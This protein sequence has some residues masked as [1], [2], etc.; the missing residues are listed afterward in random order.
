MAKV[1]LTSTFVKSATC[2]ED[3]SRIE[4]FDTATKGFSLEV[5]TSGGRTYYRR[6][7]DS[8]GRLR[9]VKLG[10]ARELSLSDARTLALR[11]G[12]DVALGEDP[13]ERKRKAKSVPTFAEFIEQQYTP[14]IKTYKRSWADDVGLLRNHLLP[15]LGKLHLDEITRQD[16]QKLHH[17]RRAAGAAP[18][19]CN[20]L[21]ILARYAFNLALRWE[22]PG[23]KANPCKGVPL[24]PEENQR[25]RYLTT[26]EAQRLYRAVCESDNPMLKYIIPALLLSGARKQEVLTARWEDFDFERRL[27]RIPVTK[28]GRPRHV[29]MSDGL[30]RLLHSVPRHDC[31]WVFPNPKTLKPFVSIFCSWDTA[32][33]RVGLTDICIHS[34]RHSHASFLINAGR[35]L[36]E[37]QRILGHTQSKTTQRY[38]HLS[39]D[40]LLDAANSVTRALEGTML[41]TVQPVA[42]PA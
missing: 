21:L 20:R 3:H 13:L 30:I 34:L 42:L 18:G 12:R 11:I 41:P 17:D 29:P 4:Y 26:E 1:L 39:H 36:Y 40:T 37:V 14:Y 25:D 5:R 7:R 27:W 22:V 33:R 10:D 8:R 19:S 15:R 31:A 16:I 2:P 38:A 24:M 23:V 6:Y 28:L 9:Q 32:R 35:T